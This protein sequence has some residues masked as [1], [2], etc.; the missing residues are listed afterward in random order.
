[1]LTRRQSILYRGSDLDAEIDKVVHDYSDRDDINDRDED[2]CSK[3]I[4]N[5]LS[6]N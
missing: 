1:M 4:A 6:T 5:E 2:E 3:N